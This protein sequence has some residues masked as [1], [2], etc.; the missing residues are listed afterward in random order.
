MQK[1]LR[2]RSRHGPARTEAWTIETRGRIDAGIETVMHWWFHPDRADEMRMRIDAT[3]A[4]DVSVAET[5]SGAVRIR[6]VIWRD[7][8]GWEHHHHGTTEL[9]HQGMAARR[10][11][12][13]IAPCNEVARLRSP[14][15]AETIVRCTARIE[16]IPVSSDYTDVL[17]VHHHVTEGGSWFGRRSLRL[18]DQKNHVGEF[19]GTLDRCRAAI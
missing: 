7:A 9:D 5:I 4:T 12:R 18:R 16:F 1:G 10:G 8:N 6:V 14:F 3:G 13:F 11:D 19:S 17:V 2:I 15:G